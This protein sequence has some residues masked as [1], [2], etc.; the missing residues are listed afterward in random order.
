[1]TLEATSLKPVEI[2]N[3]VFLAWKLPIKA[4]EERK[5]EDKTE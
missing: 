2:K 5:P 3:D 1:V 4:A